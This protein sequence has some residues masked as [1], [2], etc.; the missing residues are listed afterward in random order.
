MERLPG[1]PITYTQYTNQAEAQLTHLQL[2]EAKTKI[3]LARFLVTRLTEATWAD[4]QAE[5]DMTLEERARIRSDAAYATRLAREAVEILNSASGASSIRKDVPFRQI[6][7]DM[8]AVA[9]HAA[10]NPNAGLE[11]YGRVLLGLDPAT[12]L[13]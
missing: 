8:Q 5:F 2:A 11:V 3:E 6:F 1:R 13:I 7:R 4:A 10:L 12:T 9:L